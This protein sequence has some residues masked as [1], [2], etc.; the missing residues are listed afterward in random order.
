MNWSIS[1]MDNLKPYELEIYYAM[2]V[3][4]YKKEHDIK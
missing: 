4:E 3:I 1:E 2:T